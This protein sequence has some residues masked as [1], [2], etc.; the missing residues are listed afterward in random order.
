MNDLKNFSWQISQ[1]GEALTALAHHSKLLNQTVEYPAPP[2]VY[3]Q[4]NDSRWEQWLEATAA[5]MG[6][7]IEPVETTYSEVEH[8]VRHV[9]P[10]ILRFSCQNESR[11]LILV[12]SGWRG[13]AI[14]APD[15]TVRWLKPDII[16]VALCYGLEAP[17]VAE[18]DRVLDEADVSPKR[19]QKPRRAML[20][21]RLGV[22]RVG[23]CWL[24]RASPQAT[25][26]QQLRH[27]HL[28]RRFGVF[29]GAHAAQYFLWLLSWWL[30]G[31]GVL[32]G[33]LEP[34]WLMAWTLL[35]LTLIPLRLLVIWAEGELA[36]R[37]GGIIKQRLL[38]GALRLNP[39][40][41]RHQ[42]VGQLLGKVLESEAVE[43]LV[44]SGGFVAIVAVIELVMAVPVL[45]LG[46]GGMVNSTLF[47]IWFVGTILFTWL[48]FRKRNCWTAS[49]LEM[50][51]ELVEQMVGH[52]TRL[53][54]DR[55]A[56]WHD[57]EDQSLV[58]YLELSRAMDNT[59][60]LL[61]AL[62]SRGWLIL[63][64]LGIA[65]AFVRG[66]GSAATLAIG[67]GG[68]ISIYLAFRKLVGGI[69][70][71]VGAAVAWQQ[72]AQLF[73]AARR[74]EILGT[75]G[76]TV[77]AGIGTDSV[78]HSIPLIEAHELTFRYR[79]R[80]ATVLRS[81]NLDI[82]R[83]DKLLLEG[84]SGGG[85]STLTALLMG[86][87]EPESG[88]V[89]VDGL[90]RQTLGSAGW[91]K[92]IAAAP[93][94]HENHIL[95]ETFAFNVLM[96]RGWPPCFED[97]QEAETICC[98]LGLGD[99]LERMP[100][101]MLQMVGESGWQLSH[102]ERSRVYIA[103]ALLQ[104]ADLLILDESFAALDPETLHQTLRCVLDRANTLLVIAHP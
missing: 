53:A 45:A 47:L 69:L 74:P 31:R 92:R 56:H 52:Q 71:L 88:L 33:H 43:S 51:H 49:R 68:V 32:Q 84:P 61:M 13:I 58:H 24:L 93:Q 70:H 73:H 76:F 9:A 29:I 97:W 50:T 1:A 14:L 83:G 7:E 4:N 66:Q 12:R 96:G 18:I 41:I 44:L 86:L 77:A 42:G 3:I 95:T 89:L 87:R 28:L 63:G 75:P 91:R 16:R 17:L 57:G 80:G 59:G 2:S 40:E 82:N 25:I 21:A 102:G 37:A 101:G 27:A 64:I 35:L 23:N 100:A 65:P 79:D 78:D 15:L 19:R 85:K 36:V 67:L 81:C 5:R 10:A 20:R 26:W 46:A 6:V 94:F 99:L 30:I 62:V 55:R 38:Y 34:G 8:F 60:L 104:D 39:D 72:I 11:L 98:E 103:R 22:K 54:Q 90:D 48:Y